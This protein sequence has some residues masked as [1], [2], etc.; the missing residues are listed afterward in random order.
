VCVV[1]IEKPHKKTYTYSSVDTK[2]NRRKQSPY[3]SPP[4]VHLLIIFLPTSHLL[5]LLGK[6]VDVKL[7]GELYFPPNQHLLTLLG[8]QVNVKLAGELYFPP[9]QDLLTLLGKRVDVKLAG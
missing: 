2:V 5:T 3:Y 6:R 9:N 1:V 4:N 7:V 8:K